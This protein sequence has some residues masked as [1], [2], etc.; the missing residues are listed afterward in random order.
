MASVV[1]IH[2]LRR[3]VSMTALKVYVLGVSFWGIVALVS[4]SNVTSNFMSVASHGAGG[5]GAFLLSAVLGTTL[6]VQLTL[7]MVL[8]TT[9]SLFV[10]FARSFSRRS[11]LS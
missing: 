7:I 1:V 6:V 9:A 2:T 5:V 3:L 11:L 10:D 8:G 4:V